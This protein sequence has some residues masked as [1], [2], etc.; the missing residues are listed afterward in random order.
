[1]LR[2]SFL[3]GN[4]PLLLYLEIGHGQCLIDIK[5]SFPL[6]IPFHNKIL[7]LKYVSMKFSKVTNFL[8]CVFSMGIHA[9]DAILVCQTSE[10]MDE[11]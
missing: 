10:E 7:T 8:L 3:P 11:V 9:L 1:M 2:F 5:I 6:N 4:L